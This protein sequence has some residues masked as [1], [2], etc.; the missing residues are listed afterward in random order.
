MLEVGQRYKLRAVPGRGFCF[1]S[2]NRVNVFT[3]T[4]ITLDPS[5]HPNPPV[6]SSILS[7][8]P[9][10]IRKPMLVFTMQPEIVLYSSEYRTITESTGW[11][12]NFVP[13][14]GEK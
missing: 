5:G 1:A 7:P 6:V 14:R 10:H 12:A 9:D 11:Q 13:L 4:E 2:W 8:V 3:F